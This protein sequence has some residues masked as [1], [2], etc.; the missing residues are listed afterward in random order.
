[1]QAPVGKPGAPSSLQSGSRI[2]AAQVLKIKMMRTGTIF[3]SG[4]IY[5]KVPRYQTL[6]PLKRPENVVDGT[7]TR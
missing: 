5:I 1:M 4:E 2:Q 6:I 7:Q 3:I